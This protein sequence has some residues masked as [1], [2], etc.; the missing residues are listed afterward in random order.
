MSD[1]ERRSATELGQSGRPGG[2]GIGLALLVEIC[3]RMGWRLRFESSE[4]GGTLARLDFES[5]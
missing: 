4:S 2:H 5:S 1:D 3:E